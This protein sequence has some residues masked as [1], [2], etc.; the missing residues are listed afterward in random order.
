ME[1]RYEEYLDQGG[2]IVKRGKGSGKTLAVFAGVHGNEK[3]GIFALSKII[4]SVRIEY[5]TVYFVFANVDAIRKDVRMIEKNLNRLFFKSN[6]GETKED[7]RA[8]EL[9]A[10][11]D[12]CD[13]LIDM[14]SSNTRTSK[15]FVICESNSFDFVSN[16]DV[17]IISTGWNSTHPGATDGYMYKRGKIGMCVECGYL[18]N[19]M[20]FSD[21]AENVIKSFLVF[22][23]AVPGEIKSSVV[24]NK[25]IIHVDTMLY[26]QDK[27]LRFVKEF[28]DF[29][30]LEPHK[31]FA[32]SNTREYVA[33]TNDIIVFARGN[34]QVGGEACV[35]G[36]ELT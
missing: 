21:F 22:Y 30:K 18:G 31:P 8:R 28:D 25:R 6:S 12:Q 19:S 36:T 26:K 9:M 32:T 2:I 5:G 20:H 7:F 16:L 24:T 4:E 10:V 34:C 15:P 14:H 29:E 17:E 3:A 33:N 35:L 13:V 1:Q 23:G 27:S 11:L